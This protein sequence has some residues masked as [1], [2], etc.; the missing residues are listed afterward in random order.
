MAAAHCV[1]QLG[2]LSLAT[3][4]AQVAGRRQ[5]H[6]KADRGGV[7]KQAGPE[8]GRHEGGDHFLRTGENVI[9]I[10]NWLTFIGTQNNHASGNCANLVSS[11]ASR[12]QTV[13]CFV[14]DSTSVSATPA[15]GHE[16]QSPT[17]KN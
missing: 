3:R 15:R 6:E 9:A 4:T 12:S 8:P 14:V 5:H 7:Q 10:S 16:A 2:A 11:V 1:S 13:V 17:R